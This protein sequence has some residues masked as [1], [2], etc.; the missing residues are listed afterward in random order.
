MA[1]E[2]S[3]SIIFLG[4]LRLIFL[5]YYECCAPPTAFVPHIHV[6][7]CDVISFLLYWNSVL[8]NDSALFILSMTLTAHVAFR[9]LREIFI[10]F[11]LW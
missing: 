7:C 8:F 3:P 1:T 5:Y 10:A 4:G 2:I 11:A 6:I 9:N